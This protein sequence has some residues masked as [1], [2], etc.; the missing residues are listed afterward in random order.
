MN[1]T[2]STSSGISIND[3]ARFVVQVFSEEGRR[4]ELAFETLEEAE[5]Y[6]D[7]CFPKF[8]TQIWEI[9]ES[10]EPDY[11]RLND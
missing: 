9:P 10:K 11:E 1:T 6:A 3:K 2:S 5:E 7:Q 8:R 4:S